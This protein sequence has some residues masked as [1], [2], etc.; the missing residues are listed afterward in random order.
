LEITIDDVGP[1]RG[2]RSRSTRTSL[3]LRRSI[4]LGRS[5]VGSRWTL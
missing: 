4:G 1:L 5:V 3:H 2:T